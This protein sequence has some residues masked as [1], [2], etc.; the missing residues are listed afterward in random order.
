MSNLDQL[1]RDRHET[2]A[3]LSAAALGAPR[4]DTS[5]RPLVVRGVGAFEILPSPARPGKRYVLIA[6]PIDGGRLQRP[7][8]EFTKGL[9]ENP[10]TSTRS[11]W[12][13]LECILCETPVDFTTPTELLA[14]ADPATEQSPVRRP[15][16]A[17]L[18][19]APKRNGRNSCSSISFTATLDSRTWELDK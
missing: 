16:R 10:P 9:Y 13:A 7:H 6:T 8:D 17:S 12:D 3:D 14:Q 2:L 11:L 4:P 5:L 18:R 1:L 19:P 15:T